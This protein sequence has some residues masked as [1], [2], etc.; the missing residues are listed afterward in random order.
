M[1]VPAVMRSSKP[2]MVVCCLLCALP[3]AG[4]SAGIPVGD[5][6]TDT[7][8][9]FIEQPEGLAFSRST[10]LARQGSGSLEFRHHF[11]KGQETALA[12]KDFGRPMDLSNQ[13]G[14]HGFCAWV[15]IAGGTDRWE[16]QMATHSGEDWT[17]S[18]GK[19]RQ[20]LDPGWHRV[21]ILRE[22]IADVG[23]IQTVCVLV[24]N[25]TEDVESAVHIDGVEAVVFS[26]P[27]KE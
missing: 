10:T 19:L 12:R 18:A 16:L 20:R 5:F 26:A 27:D 3:A 14:F 6:E 25:F 24:K 21:D 8:G 7:E 9:W 13:A 22:E 2:S 23:R 1:P 4:R 11:R 17:W 15:H